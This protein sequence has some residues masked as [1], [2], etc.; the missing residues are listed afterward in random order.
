MSIRRITIEKYSSARPNFRRPPPDLG[1]RSRLRTGSLSFSPAR[2]SDG[3]HPK[4]SVSCFR[5]RISDASRSLLFWFGFVFFFEFSPPW[6]LTT[7]E[8][9]ER[10]PI[11]SI[12]WLIYSLRAPCEGRLYKFRPPMLFL[13]RRESVLLF[14]S[15][16][17]R[18]R[19]LVFYFSSEE[20]SSI[21]FF[22]L[23]MTRN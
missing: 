19:R 1:N 16:S 22:L 13:L 5:A 6:D 15:Y 10:D 20:L 18:P 12:V 14:I 11:L 7:K 8:G 4:L 17:F 2:P 9:T 21:A 3:D 23:V